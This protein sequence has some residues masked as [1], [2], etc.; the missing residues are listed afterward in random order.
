MKLIENNKKLSTICRNAE[1]RTEKIV[2]LNKLELQVIF[3]EINRNDSFF[4]KS[5]LNQIWVNERKFDP[6]FAVVSIMHEVG[7]AYVK[8]VN[9]GYLCLPVFKDPLT[10]APL[11]E[12][13]IVDYLVCQWG[14]M[15]DLIELRK[16]DDELC[17][18]LRLWQ[19]E[20]KC[21]SALIRFQLRKLAGIL[22]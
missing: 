15:D 20:P 7:H 9:P 22:Q 1:K 3:K 2:A 17:D 13:L 6:K 8:M 5:S 11:S 18:A 12:E 16:N 10:L 14:F 19:D 21:V 4:Y